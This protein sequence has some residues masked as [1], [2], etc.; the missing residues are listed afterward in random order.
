MEHMKAKTMLIEIAI[1]HKQAWD[2]DDSKAMARAEE[3]ALI[4]CDAYDYPV[5]SPNLL[6]ASYWPA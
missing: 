6:L 2:V 1:R 3:E 5:N 4:V